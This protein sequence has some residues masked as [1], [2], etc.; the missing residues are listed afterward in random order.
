MSIP[1]HHSCR[2]PRR[3]KSSPLA[4]FAFM[5]L[6]AVV[7]PQVSFAQTAKKSNILVIFG[8]DIGQANIS[9]YTHG[10]DRDRW[11]QI[12]SRFGEAD[13]DNAYYRWLLGGSQAPS[14]TPKASP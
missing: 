2:N 7:I 5:L 4:I 11:A 14:G 9:R 13:L 6:A 3:H 12:V 1:L 8:D 10:G